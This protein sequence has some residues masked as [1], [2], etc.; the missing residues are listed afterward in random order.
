MKI[1]L[2]FSGQGAQY[3]GMGKDL[4]E[5]YELAEDYFDYAEDVLKTPIKKICFEGSEEELKKTENTQPAVLLMSFICCKLLVEEGFKF[6]TF[7]GFSLGEYSALAASGV[8]SLDDA[9]RIV[10]ERGLI[11]EK[12][13]PSGKGGMAAI[14]GLEDNVVEDICKKV[15]GIVVPANYN[16]PGQLVISGE[17]AAVEKACDL[18]EEADAKRTVILNVSGPF[19]SPLLIDASDELKNVLDNV[20]FNSLKDYRVISNVSADYHNDQ[21]IKELLIKQMYSPVRWRDSIERLISDGYDTFIEVGPGKT[22]TGFMR[23]I[24]REKK[25]INVG[26]VESLK[27][28]L[29]FLKG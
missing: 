28:A 19:H 18:A 8:M 13:V 5:N 2:L 27:K 21:K 1:A 17:A 26:D 20:D 14:L 6:D 16:S 4:Y 29:E 7:A 9:L 25:A 22:L 3:V 11:M 23:S 24:N 12:A 10:R 15:D